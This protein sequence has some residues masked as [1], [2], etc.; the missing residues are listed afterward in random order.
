VIENQ[1]LTVHAGAG[2]VYDSD[3]EKERIETVTKARAIQRALQL[4]TGNTAGDSR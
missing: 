2:I 1:R 4:A 3:P